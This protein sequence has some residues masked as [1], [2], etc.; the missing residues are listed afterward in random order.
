MR[1]R[2]RPGSV[3]GAES[4]RKCCRCRWHRGWLMIMRGICGNHPSRG[5]PSSTRPGGTVREENVAYRQ[6]ANGWHRSEKFG[7]VRKLARAS[8]GRRI[9]CILKRLRN[10]SSKQPKQHYYLKELSQALYYLKRRNGV[11]TLH[12]LSVTR[13]RVRVIRRRGSQECQ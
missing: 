3:V 7:V 12:S 4:M 5:H 6:D 9:L 2:K 11:Q 8:C 13:R 1:L 10:G